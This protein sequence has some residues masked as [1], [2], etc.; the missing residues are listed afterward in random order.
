MLIVHIVNADVLARS[1]EL[2]V[3]D[4]AALADDAHEPQGNHDDGN[5]R[6]GNLDGLA[7]ESLSDADGRGGETDVGEYEGPPL[8]REAH[9]PDAVE[10]RDG[11][12]GGEPDRDEPQEER[13]WHRHRV[14]QLAHRKGGDSQEI[15]RQGRHGLLPERKEASAS[16]SGR[17]DRHVHAWA[18]R[19]VRHVV[20]NQ[21]REID[22]VDHEGEDPTKPLPGK[23][24]YDEL[25]GGLL[26]LHL[27]NR[28]RHHASNQEGVRREDPNRHGVAGFHLFD[29][30][31]DVVL[32]DGHD[33][34]TGVV[35]PEEDPHRAQEPR[36]TCRD[37]V[38]LHAVDDEGH[39]GPEAAKEK[40]LA[41]MVKTR[42]NGAR[43]TDEA[44]NNE[45]EQ[46][47]K[48][49]QADDIKDL[50]NSHQASKGVGLDREEDGDGA[51]RETGREP[52]P[53]DSDGSLRKGQL[54][55]AVG[56]VRVSA[57]SSFKIVAI[58]LFVT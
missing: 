47:E 17:T 23:T 6:S 33:H 22:R 43:L 52:S 44:G 54:R 9:L 24:T 35:D 31:D 37:A 29:F 34:G 1:Q 26:G 53:C 51:G 16:V 5:H 57:G 41:R 3:P 19:C 4:S 55:A 38:D 42:A 28:R 18:N 48:H 56:V 20:V 40:A 21:A 45:T 36:T 25:N 2:P 13:S 14:P 8:Q 32:H 12:Q 15:W 39:R 27:G 50:A 7:V 30:E 10:D 58:R 11:R 46:S 49:D